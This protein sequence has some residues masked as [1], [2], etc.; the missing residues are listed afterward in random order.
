MPV[1]VPLARICKVALSNTVDPTKPFPVGEDKQALA[2]DLSVRTQPPVVREV[3]RYLALLRL[4]VPVLVLG[5]TSL[6]N[7]SL[8]RRVNTS[9]ALG[10][11]NLARLVNTIHLVA[12]STLPT[13]TADLA[14]RLAVLDPVAVPVVARTKRFLEINSALATRAVAL[15]GTELDITALLTMMIAE[16]VS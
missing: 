3:L 13:T 1:S 2:T 9:P 7:T 14:V 4:A 6:V 5:T 16:A 10:N 12:N 8:A 11:T 15:A